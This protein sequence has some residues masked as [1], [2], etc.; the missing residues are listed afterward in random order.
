M[1]FQDGR[2]AFWKFRTVEK[3]L[4]H[5]TFYLASANAAKKCSITCL[6]QIL[7]W[8]M[9]LPSA[10]FLTFGLFFFVLFISGH[11][12]NFI[13][14]LFLL[15]K[16][17]VLTIFFLQMFFL[18]DWSCFNSKYKKIMRLS[19]L[20]TIQQKVKF[21]SKL[22]HQRTLTLYFTNIIFM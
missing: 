9:F 18:N 5:K 13:V 16:W 4:E 22:I 12:W 2:K 14:V 6:E 19:K 20:Q 17:K 7:F 11:M 1:V 10:L 3:V 8:L 21:T 15:T